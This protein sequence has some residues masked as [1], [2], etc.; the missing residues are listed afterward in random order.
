MKRLS[1]AAALFLFAFA[2]QAQDD[3]SV[4]AQF[5]VGAAAAFADYT[6][7]PSFPIDD[8]GLG[9]QF[10]VQATLSGSFAAEVGYFN[11]GSFEQDIDPGESDGPVDIQLG[12]F[13]IAGLYYLPVFEDAET[14]I[15]LFVK[16]GLYDYDI[17]LT[18]VEG[19]SRIPGSLGHSTGFFGGGG[20]VLNVSDNVGVRATVDWYDIDNADLWSLGLGAEYRF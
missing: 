10:Y 3:T 17:D 5:R 1:I 13:N 6:G 16:I 9:V 18:V 15:D 8:S 14:D 12:G 11:S 2:T 19:N 20:F 7:D 4:Q